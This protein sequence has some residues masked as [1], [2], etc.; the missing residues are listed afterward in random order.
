MTEAEAVHL[1]LAELRRRR[2]EGVR[3]VGLTAE[4][5]AALADLIRRAKGLPAGD[6][7]ASPAR[8][9]EAAARPVAR[10]PAAPMPAAKPAAP[11]APKVDDS[12][13]PEPPELAVPETGDKAGRLAWLRGRILACEVSARQ[14][15]AGAKPVLA[16]GNADAAILLVDESPEAEDE[17]SGEPFRGPSGQILAKALAA[18]E[19]GPDAVYLARLMR[20]RPTLSSGLGDR[21]PTA[22]E[23]AFCLPYLRAEI[24]L[25]RPKVV[26]ALGN[27]ALNG[28]L[29][30]SGDR[31]LRI[32]EQRGKW[33]DLGGIPVMPT[34][35]P[36]YLLRNPSPAAKREFWTDLL[37]VMER[38][39]LPVSERQRGFY[40]AKPGQRGLS[41]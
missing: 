30:L 38:V 39:G 16:G 35:K 2:S 14:R 31:A 12:A 6:A 24:A 36:S 3:T 26:V 37:A 28:L 10:V 29:G 25:V 18:M 7:P 23:A 22:R 5:E 8:A 41:E 13:I 40:A 11:S 34:Y 15:A 9:A 33:L 17:A 20:W 1:L 19:L 32:T 4:G 27:A 21:P